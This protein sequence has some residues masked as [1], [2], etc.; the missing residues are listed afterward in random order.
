MTN[1]TTAGHDGTE[2]VITHNDDGGL[3]Y[4]E[5]AEFDYEV[6][7]RF[8]AGEEMKLHIDGELQEVLVLYYEIT[9]RSREYV[10]DE[11]E[12]YVRYGI[13]LYDL[14]GQELGDEKLTTE[15]IAGDGCEMTDKSVTALQSELLG[16]QLA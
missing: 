6:G 2:T 4:V 12:W 15:D 8:A 16:K 1:D 7:D 3:E 14:R 11:R 5:A 10:V 9:S 13:T